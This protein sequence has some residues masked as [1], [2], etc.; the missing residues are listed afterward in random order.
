MG[1]E[2]DIA[3]GKVS[4]WREVGDKEGR[5]REHICPSRSCVG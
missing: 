5:C 2:R 4:G 3:R 1:S